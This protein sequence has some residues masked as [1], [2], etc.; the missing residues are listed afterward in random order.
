M[1]PDEEVITKLR[2]WDVLLRN[3]APGLHVLRS[4]LYLNRD[5]DDGFHITQ[6]GTYELVVNFR[7][8]EPPPTQP[9]QP[10]EVG[11]LVSSPDL[12]IGTWVGMELHGLIQRFNPDGT[13]YV[14]SLITNPSGPPD[15]I[16][17]YRFDGTL[18]AIQ[19]VNAD[20]MEAIG[21]GSCG[22]TITGTY[23]VYL[24]GNGNIRLEVI[25]DTCEP[26]RSSTSQLHTPYQP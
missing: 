14:W 20:G 9:P 21:M 26:R 10:T 11:T 13:L 24:L 6:A 3:P 23:E 15:A 22:T 4:V 5:V 25:T 1:D 19:E 18:M 16:L 12:I 7:I 17:S 8:A 2:S